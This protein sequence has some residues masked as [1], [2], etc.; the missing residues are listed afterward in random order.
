[1][2]LYTN[3][4]CFLFGFTDGLSF[5]RFPTLNRWIQFQM[6]L[7]RFSEFGVTSKNNEDGGEVVINRKFSTK[8]PRELDTDADSEVDDSM[9]ISSFTV[10]S[11]IQTAAGHD[12]LQDS[13]QYLSAENDAITVLTFDW[14]NEEPYEKAVER[15][16]LVAC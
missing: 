4:P 10:L 14:E 5:G 9:G 7:H 16:S 12:A 15:Y 1:M 3:Q 6:N 8:R 2:N 11:D 13:M